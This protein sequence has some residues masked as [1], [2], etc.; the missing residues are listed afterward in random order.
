MRKYSSTNIKMIGRKP[1]YP[2]SPPA[3][4]AKAGEMITAELRKGN[5]KL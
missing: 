3:D 1:M 2:G 4:W 5:A